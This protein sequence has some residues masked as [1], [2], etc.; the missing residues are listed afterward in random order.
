[1]SSSTIG[2]QH[3]DQVRDYLL[4]LQDTICNTIQQLDGHGGFVEDTWQRREGGG[5]RSRV[6][7][8]GA[9]FEKAG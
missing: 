8:D 5:G 6:M 1:M 9:I 4:N 3:I 2:K 7:E